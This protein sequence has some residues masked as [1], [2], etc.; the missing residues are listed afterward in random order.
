MKEKRV[1][2]IKDA[3]SQLCDEISVPVVCSLAAT[4]C[5]WKISVEKPKSNK[6]YVRGIIIGDDAFIE[7][8]NRL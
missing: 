2:E 3:I 5:G 7:R 4:T 1:K 8:H 6:D